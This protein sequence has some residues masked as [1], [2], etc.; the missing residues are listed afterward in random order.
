MKKQTFKRGSHKDIGLFILAH[1]LSFPFIALLK[2]V[3]AWLFIPCLVAMH[4]GIALFLLSK[5]N[6]EA[7]EIDIR[8]HLKTVYILLALYLPLLL[9]RLMSAIFPYDVQPTYLA[10]TTAVLTLFITIVSVL[11]IAALTRKL[12]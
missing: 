1:I 2:I 5:R 10:I 3:P 11:N 8:L 9:Y 12:A 7:S 6:F 4:I